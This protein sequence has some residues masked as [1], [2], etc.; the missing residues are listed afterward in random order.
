MSSVEIRKEN[1]K[2]VVNLKGKQYLWFSPY[3]DGYYK[4]TLLLLDNL[5]LQNKTLIYPIL[6]NF[7]HYLELWIKLLLLAINDSN[8]VKDLKIDNHSIQKIIKDEVNNHKSLLEL[9]NVDT[10]ALYQIVNKYSYF[11]GF[12]CEATNLSMATRYPLSNKGSNIII[13]FDKVE[14]AEY[15]NY[16]DLKTNVLDILK[17]TS[18]ITKD[19]FERY[20]LILLKEEESKNE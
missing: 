10:N 15:E 3:L 16:A 19:F 17:I 13:N 7:S 5:N 12:I 1:D 14:E 9:Y 8:N 20:F 18:Q 4:S 11:L 6:L 2:T